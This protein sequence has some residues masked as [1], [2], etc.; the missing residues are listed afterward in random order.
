MCFSYQ[1]FGFNFVFTYFEISMISAELFEGLDSILKEIRENGEPF[2][3]IQ[4]V[5]QIVHVTC[6]VKPFA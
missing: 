6:R 2:G 3:G 1:I 5:C 4:M